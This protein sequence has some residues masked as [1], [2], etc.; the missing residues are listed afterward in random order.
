MATPTYTLLSTITLGSN[1]NAVDFTSINQGFRHL[2][3][4]TTYAK[5]QDANFDVRFNNSTNN[6][7]WMGKVF[8]TQYDASHPFLEI[9]I[10]NDSRYRQRQ[11]ILRILNY[12]VTNESTGCIWQ[13]GFDQTRSDNPNGAMASDWAIGGYTPNNAI[14]SINM[15]GSFTAGSKFELYGVN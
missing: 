7:Y 13:W 4:W 12:S 11:A 15:T 2:V 9:E 5:T 8:G 14:N 10:N 6:D 1:T 3:L